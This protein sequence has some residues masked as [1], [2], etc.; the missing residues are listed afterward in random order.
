M[1]QRSPDATAN[2][3]HGSRAMKTLWA[4]VL[5]PLLLGVGVAVVYAVCTAFLGS[6]V[7]VDSWPSLWVHIKQEAEHEFVLCIIVSA[8]GFGYRILRRFDMM[9]RRFDDHRRHLANL[10]VRRI[11]LQYKVGAITN[12]DIRNALTYTA[13]S[14]ATILARK[15]KYQTTR[16][17]RLTQET[18]EAA[19]DLEKFKIRVP[20]ERTIPF[21]KDEFQVSNQVFATSFIDPS[22]EFWDTD[23]G[24]NYFD[25]NKERAD[26]QCRITRLFI[27]IKPRIAPHDYKMI[28]RH[29]TESKIESLV[30]TWDLIKDTFRDVPDIQDFA[31]FIDSKRISTWPPLATRPGATWYL[32][33]ATEYAK[34]I[35]VMETLRRRI[36][37]GDVFKLNF[38]DDLDTAMEALHVT[39]AT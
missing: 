9:E 24:Q 12:N 27:F 19:R 17:G 34:I 10:F 2:G 33:G 4:D 7:R 5:W 8:F 28:K 39:V 22:V 20:P 30:T 3:K 1:P 37:T 15:N 13:A 16:L 18:F 31:F 23:E 35:E 29:I 14:T 26:A 38:S 21:V 32:E 6:G 11:D 25:M 36:K